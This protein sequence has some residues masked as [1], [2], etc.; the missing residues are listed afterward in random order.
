MKLHRSKDNIILPIDTLLYALL[1]L[2][3]TSIISVALV[4]KQHYELLMS[5]YSK[6]GQY[7]W[8]SLYER[9]WKIVNDGHE[10]E[11]WLHRYKT[12][13]NSSDKNFEEIT[14]LGH[15]IQYAKNICHK[16][17]QYK[18]EADANDSVDADDIEPDQSARLY[19]QRTIVSALG[20]QE[21]LMINGQPC[22]ASI[23]ICRRR[24]AFR[25]FPVDMINIFTFARERHAYL[26]LATVVQPKVTFK[27]YELIDIEDEFA[28]LMVRDEDELDHYDEKICVDM[29][30]S[31]LMVPDNSMGVQLID[32][33]NGGECSNVIHVCVMRACGVERII[34]YE[35]VKEEL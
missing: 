34:S 28:V 11:C 22:I 33:F 14:V 16:Q 19:T 9:R 30:R 18:V 25:K 3:E 6:Y 24:L 15:K 1:F 32:L 35:V 17:Y 8:K 31:D 4:N 27:M 21:L 5:S 12:K 10:R 20:G 2:N 29:I 13:H 7:V 23:S 26:L